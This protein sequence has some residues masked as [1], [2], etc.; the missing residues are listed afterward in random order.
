MVTELK[1]EI[2]ALRLEVQELEAALMQ[3]KHASQ[4]MAKELD[5]LCCSQTADT[6]TPAERS[7]VAIT[8]RKPR[9]SRHMP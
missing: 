3:E 6:A 9:E 5:E 4:S 2:S 7:Y 1:G 8:G